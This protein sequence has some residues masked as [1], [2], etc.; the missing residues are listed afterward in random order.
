MVRPGSVG[1]V[2]G[3]GTIGDDKH[4]HILIQTTSSPE[5]VPLV[6]V[7]LVEGF[8]ELDT[9]SFE[10]HMYQGK[11][12]DKDGHIISGVMGSILLHILVDD[13]DK[14]VV[15]VGLVNQIDVLA[16]TSVPFKYL[17][18]VLLYLGCLDYNIIIL[19]CNA[20]VE[21][22]LPL[23]VCK[24]VGVELLQLGP[25]I[26]NQVSLCVDGKVLI[27]LF[28][29]K[30][31]ELLF[32]VSLTLVCIRSLYC[33]LIFRDNSIFLAFCYDIVLGHLCFFLFEGQ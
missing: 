9:P 24:V 18:V 22:G 20:G 17:D 8:F 32:Q 6:S 15:D 2:L 28:P 14:V 25:E 3:V 19:V 31:D 30:V 26:G 11:T 16:L 10:L 33:L 29:Q 1:V 4:L 13:L 23:I 5:T 27:T 12:I 21:E 7:Y